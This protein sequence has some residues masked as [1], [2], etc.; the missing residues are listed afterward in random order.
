MTPLTAIVLAAGEA[1]RMRSSRPKVLHPLCGRPL[2]D[3]PVRA[4]RAL[5]A[6]LVL[7]V[8]RAADDVRAAVGDA[9][10]LAFVEQKQRLGTG[11]A[12]LQARAA[13]ADAAG[14]ILVLPGDMPLV[15]EATLARLIGH[16]QATGAACTILS[17]IQDDPTGYGR[18]VRDGRDGRRGSSS[19]GTRRRPSARSARSAPASIASTRGGSGPPSSRSRPRTSRASTT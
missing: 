6:R 8:G 4:C 5:G 1:K 13:C 3:Y 16:H 12:V 15:G 2:I 19:T 10:D 9:A 11:H 14:T 18:V 17:A 7:V